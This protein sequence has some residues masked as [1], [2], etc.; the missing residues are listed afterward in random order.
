MW[1]SVLFR[2]LETPVI[3]ASS[4]RQVQETKISGRNFTADEVAS[5]LAPSIVS[6]REMRKCT[7]Q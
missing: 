2:C 6:Q 3:S 1:L 7:F 4:Q 5:C